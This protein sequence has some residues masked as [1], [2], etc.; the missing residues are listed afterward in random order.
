M[1]H[2]YDFDLNIVYIGKSNNIHTGVIHNCY[3]AYLVYGYI[4]VHIFL[5]M[6]DVYK[7]Y[8]YHIVSFY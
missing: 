5:D 8:G 7:Y 1:L 4:Y 3:S 6:N 2:I